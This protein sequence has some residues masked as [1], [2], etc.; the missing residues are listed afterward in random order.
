MAV[1]G[2]KGHVT[3]CL[4]GRCDLFVQ[5]AQGV[6]GQGGRGNRVPHVVFLTA[7]GSAKS[8]VGL[9]V[10]RKDAGGLGPGDRCGVDQR[11]QWAFV[12]T[13]SLC[14][15][16]GLPSSAQSLRVPG[17]T[18]GP[19]AHLPSWARQ[20]GSGGQDRREKALVFS[21][22]P[23]NPEPSSRARE[24]TPGGGKPPTGAGFTRR[25]ICYMMCVS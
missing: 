24:H 13:I 15:Q 3:S 6:R 8:G 7:R 23:P 4:G 14:P 16:W 12:V 21:C 20:S 25:G 19:A 11:K 2:Y 22:S 17:V 9:R 18:R 1:S 5:E 10:C